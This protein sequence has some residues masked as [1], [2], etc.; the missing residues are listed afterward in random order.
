MA[1]WVFTDSWVTVNCYDKNP[2]RGDVITLHL[3][4]EKST[5]IKRVMA[6]EGDIVEIRQGVAY[7]NGKE[8]VC[9]KYVLFS[10]PKSMKKVKIPKGHVFIVGD[11]RPYSYDSRIIGPVPAKY[12]EG[13]V[14]FRF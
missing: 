7:V 3:K 14:V 1:P 11:H 13:V 9:E 10:D 8:S 5:W 2:D 6:L 4:G 12:I